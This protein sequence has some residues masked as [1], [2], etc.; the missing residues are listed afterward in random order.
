MK[1]RLNKRHLDNEL[2]GIFQLQVDPL[3]V[4]YVPKDEGNIEIGERGLPECILTYK[5]TI[6]TPQQ[7]PELYAIPHET[8]VKQPEEVWLKCRNATVILITEKED[9]RFRRENES[10]IERIEALYVEL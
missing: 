7:E 3:R 8:D 9:N 6:P 10:L 5:S 2:N 4:A 1:V